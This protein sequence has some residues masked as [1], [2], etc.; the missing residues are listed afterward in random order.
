MAQ[1]SLPGVNVTAP[2]A[3]TFD[4]LGASNASFFV[5]L[6]D[7]QGGEAR[8]VHVS[9]LGRVRSSID[10]DND[11]VYESPVDGSDLSCS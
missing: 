1:D 2:N 6:C 11:A 9:S 7:A 4:A 10:H 5:R 8:A 3:V